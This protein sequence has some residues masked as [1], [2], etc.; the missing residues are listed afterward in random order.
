LDDATEGVLLGA[1]KSE[2]YDVRMRR[3]NE[4]GDG[5]VVGVMTMVWKGM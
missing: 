2:Y 5:S 3:E 4:N 1:V